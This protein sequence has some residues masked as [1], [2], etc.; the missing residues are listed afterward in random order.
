MRAAAHTPVR[1]TERL[2]EAGIDPSIGSVLAEDQ[3]QAWP[4][5]GSRTAPPAVLL[6]A[7]PELGRHEGIGAQVVEEV[8]VHIHSRPKHVRTMVRTRL[9]QQRRVHPITPM[10]RDTGILIHHHR[11]HHVEVELGMYF[12]SANRDVQMS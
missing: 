11:Q 4:V 7:G 1:F 6:D 10:R 8:A 12:E 9:C 3:R 2:V 5:V